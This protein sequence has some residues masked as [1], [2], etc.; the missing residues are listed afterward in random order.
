MRFGEAI[1]YED[2]TGKTRIDTFAQRYM[3]MS[4]LEK[5]EFKNALELDKYLHGEEIE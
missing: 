1:G 3:D 2:N 4:H 5:Y